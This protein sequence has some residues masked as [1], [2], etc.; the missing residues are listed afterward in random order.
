M[1]ETQRKWLNYKDISV[2][3][4]PDLASLILLKT[5]LVNNNYVYNMCHWF[6]DVKFFTIQ[7]IIDMAMS[8]SNEKNVY[9][10]LCFLQ[11]YFGVHQILILDLINFLI[12]FYQDYAVSKKYI[13]ILSYCFSDNNNKWVFE[14]LIKNIDSIPSEF[15]LFWC[16]DFLIIKGIRKV[17]KISRNSVISVKYSKNIYCVIKRKLYSIKQCRKMDLIDYLWF[18]KSK[19][20]LTNF[21]REIM[22]YLFEFFNGDCDE[23]CFRC[24]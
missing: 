23:N 2:T 1:L 21:P 16:Q 4:N 17:T 3:I 5:K 15:Q 14:S 13:N 8:E 12:R 22:F 10:N 18:H 24:E 20:Y 9:V 6:T 19:S 11:E 7:S